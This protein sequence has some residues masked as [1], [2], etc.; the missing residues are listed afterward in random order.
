MTKESRLAVHL[1]SQMYVA[2]VQA[3]V[4]FRALMMDV[5]LL[6]VVVGIATSSSSSAAAQ[7]PGA[8]AFARHGNGRGNHMVQMFFN[9][10]DQREFGLGLQRRKGRHG[11]VLCGSVCLRL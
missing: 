6:V 10:L 8:L 5:L 3:R 9:R 7:Q 4:E 2:R 11:C 1:Q